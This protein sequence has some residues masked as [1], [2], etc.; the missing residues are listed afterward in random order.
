MKI[1]KYKNSHLL[2]NFGENKDV[3]E[4]LKNKKNSI[5]I[6]SHFAEINFD[7]F[8][9]SAPDILQHVLTCTLNFSPATNLKIL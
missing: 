7:L 4:L 9:V 5:G 3:T 1:S 6:N 2:I 8:K